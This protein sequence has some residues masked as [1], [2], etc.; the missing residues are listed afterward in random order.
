[1]SKHLLHRFEFKVR[2]SM[3]EACQFG[4]S[5]LGGTESLVHTRVT[6]EGIIRANHGLGVRAVIDVDFQNAFPSLLHD[7]LDSVLER[8]YPNYDL[9]PSVA[10]TTVEY[11]FSIP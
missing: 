2:Q 9:G 10:K 3:I 7:A 4:V 1:M 8:G 5:I 6:I 11:F